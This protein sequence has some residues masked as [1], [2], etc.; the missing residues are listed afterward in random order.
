MSLGCFPKPRLLA[1]SRFLMVSS[2]FWILATEFV[3]IR[4]LLLGKALAPRLSL[5]QK[6][7][8]G[9]PNEATIPL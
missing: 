8:I 4:F 5:V 9:L 6:C 1:V 2:R 7:L 3:P